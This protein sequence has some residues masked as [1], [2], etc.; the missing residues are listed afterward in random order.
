[1]EKD[2]SALK[3]SSACNICIFSRVNGNSNRPVRGVIEIGRVDQRRTGRVQL[4][5]EILVRTGWILS[6]VVRQ[7]SVGQ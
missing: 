2:L 7:N 4:R 5:N 6:G 1:M 3:E